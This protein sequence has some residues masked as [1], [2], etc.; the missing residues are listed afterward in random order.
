MVLKKDVEYIA[1]DPKLKTDINDLNDYKPDMVFICVPTPMN[2]DG[3]QNIDIVNNVIKEIY[4]FDSN[5]L[6][7]LKSTILPNYTQDISK[8]SKNLVINPEFLREKFADNDFVNS[9]IIVF[10]GEEIVKKYQI[11]IKIILKCIFR[12]TL[13]LM[14]SFCFINKIYN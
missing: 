9:E 7:V 1:I 5:I 4:T 13:L 12:I 6:I 14:L 2:D 10:G 8:I 11:F 3:T